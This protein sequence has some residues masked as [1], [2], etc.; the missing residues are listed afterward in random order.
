MENFHLYLLPIGAV[1]SLLHQNGWLYQLLLLP[2]A[3]IHQY[4]LDADKVFLS[5]KKGLLQVRLDNPMPKGMLNLLEKHPDTIWAVEYQGFLRIAG[6]TE[7]SVWQYK[8]LENGTDELVLEAGTTGLLMAER[9]LFLAHLPKAPYL[10]P[11]YQVFSNAFVNELFVT[12]QELAGV[13]AATW[14]GIP[15]L[16]G[17]QDNYEMLLRIPDGLPRKKA[18]L[19]LHS[20]QTAVETDVTLEIR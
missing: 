7:E 8:Q 14:N 16:I 13:V 17:Y 18:A 15:L 4:K 19:V 2:N 11:D 3:I 20:A 6:I 9:G 5:Q 1:K 10:N 12:G